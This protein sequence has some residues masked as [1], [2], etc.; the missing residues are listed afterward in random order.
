[1]RG[2]EA[3]VADVRVAVVV[4]VVV[5]AAEEAS[6]VDMEVG[7]ATKRFSRIAQ[8]RSHGLD[9]FVRCSKGEYQ[10]SMSRMSQSRTCSHPV[11]NHH[12]ETGGSLNRVR[13]TV[14]KEQI[15]EQ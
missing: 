10:E 12:A 7:A 15:R 1:M 11:A 14:M 3:D 2:S 6:G 8:K 4:V 5:A 13:V 9:R